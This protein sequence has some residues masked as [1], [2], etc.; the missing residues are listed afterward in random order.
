M[1]K[2]A[3]LF[4]YQVVKKQLINVHCELLTKKSLSLHDFSIQTTTEWT[5]NS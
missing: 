1:E 2:I 3:S 5:I 4:L